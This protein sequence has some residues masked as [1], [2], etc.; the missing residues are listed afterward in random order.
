MEL[1]IVVGL[2]CR[3]NKVLTTRRL[4]KAHLG[5]MWEFPGGKR[6]TGETETAA[7]QREMREELGVPVMVGNLLHRER[8]A[9]P[10][11]TV[12]LAFYLCN[13]DPQANEPQPLAASE[14]AWRARE[15][16]HDD[17]FPPANKKV[18]ALLRAHLAS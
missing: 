17:D 12:N 8:H 10:D 6:E 9:Y 15:E 7:L 11:R 3:E 14:M 1:D 13:L 18:L 4:K 2:I 5:G 16:L